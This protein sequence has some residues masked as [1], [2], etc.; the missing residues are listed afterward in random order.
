MH[1]ERLSELD[2][3]EQRIRT[4]FRAKTLQ[5]RA[6]AQLSICE[7]AGLIGGHREQLQRVY[8]Q[9]ILP[10]RFSVGRGMIYGF[11]H[12]SREVDVVIWDELNYMSLPLTDHSFFF[13]ES[14][15]LAMEC[16]SSWSP[17]EMEDVLLKS[18]TVREIIPMHEPTLGDTVLK[19]AVEIEA[20]RTGAAHGGLMITPPHIGTAAIFLK[21]GEKFGL[22]FLTNKMIQ[23]LDDS[24]PDAL[25]LLDAGKVVLKRYATS[26]AE[27][28]FGGIGWL[29][30]YELGDD[31]LL[32]FTNSLLALLEQRSVMIES[33]FYLG[34]Y[35]KQLA[36][37]APVATVDFRLTRPIPE[38]FPLWN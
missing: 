28:S 36:Q 14:V 7:H 22:D 32:V 34:R 13:A 19:L 4:Y 30:F 16:K 6:L 35:T 8:L 21:G 3:T 20:V 23:D 25:L 33:P 2:E 10:K 31:A 9:E 24:W 26:K 5:L 37:I 11:L 29:E 18:Q 27:G 15:R 17:S 38:S 12:R 1:D